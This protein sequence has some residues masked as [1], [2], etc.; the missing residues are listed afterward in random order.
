MG[1]ERASLW[2]LEN[3][4][5]EPKESG[6]DLRISGDILL[7]V[8]NVSNIGSVSLALASIFLDGSLSDGFTS[9]SVANIMTLNTNQIISGVK[10]IADDVS[11]VIGTG[12]DAIWSL[13]TVE[14]SVLLDFGADPASW[15]INPSNQNIDIIIDADATNNVWVFDSGNEN[16]TIGST[17]ISNDY[18]LGLLGTGV[19]AMVETTTPTADANHGKIYTKTDNQLY[20]QDGAGAEKEI[21]N[22][23]DAQTITGIKT[24]ADKIAFTQS[25]LNEFIDSEADGFLDYSVTTAHR[26]RMSVADTDVRLEFIGT[27]NSGLLEWKE[28]EDFFEFSDDILMA[29]SEKI[30]FIDTA[31]FIE[32]DTTSEVIQFGLTGETVAANG[33]LFASVTDSNTVTNLVTEVSFNQN[34]SIPA[35]FMVPGRVIKFTAGGKYS[36]TSGSQTMRLRFKFLSLSISIVLDTG[37]IAMSASQTNKPWFFTGI[38]IIRTDGVSGTLSANGFVELDRIDAPVGNASTIV[39]NTTISQQITI[40]VQWGTASLSNQITMQTFVIESLSNPT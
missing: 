40:T 13:E 14:G 11:F 5:L 32:Y 19:L 37:A 31:N 30:F 7:T 4:I 24:F 29:S 6:N 2:K 9:V 26:F 20:F 21:V 33:T 1:M 15:K 28:D 36:T 10:T 17:S 39:V 22:V 25:D 27:T 38:A 34:H 16:L 18:D 3:G 35:D 8:N 23:A 12:G